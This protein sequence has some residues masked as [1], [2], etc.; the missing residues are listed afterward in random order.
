METPVFTSPVMVVD[1]N[2]QN[3]SF[4]IFEC[5]DDVFITDM[6]LFVNGSSDNLMKGP[7][8]IQIGYNDTFDEWSPEITVPLIPGKLISLA[9]LSAGYP[10]CYFAGGDAVFLKVISPPDQGSADITIFGFGFPL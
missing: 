3:Q 5:V 1:T 9:A 10:R 7:I 8:K 4:Q 6:R 2:S